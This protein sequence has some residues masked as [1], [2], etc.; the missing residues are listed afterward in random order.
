MEYSNVQNE[1]KLI[2]N[3]DTGIQTVLA[4]TSRTTE[5]KRKGPNASTEFRERRENVRNFN[6]NTSIF[7]AATNVTATKAHCS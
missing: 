1:D 6:Y 4:M 2:N 3:V 7:I 5:G